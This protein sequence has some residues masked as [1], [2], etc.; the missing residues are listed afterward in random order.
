MN[1]KIRIMKA[2]DHKIWPLPGF[3]SIN[4]MISLLLKMMFSDIFLSM[5][6]Y[7]PWTQEMC[8]EVVHIEPHSLAFIPDLFKTEEMCNKAVG[9]NLYTLKFIPVCLRTAEICKR[10]VEKYLCPMRDVPDHLKIQ[11][12]CNKAVK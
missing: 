11:E 3:K 9:V 4:K 1:L 2:K 8:N 12:M 6:K 5:V 7:I 10:A